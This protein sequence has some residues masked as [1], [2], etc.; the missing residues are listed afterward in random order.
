MWAKKNV[1]QSRDVRFYFDSLHPSHV[2]TTLPSVAGNGVVKVING[3]MQSPASKIIDDDIDASAEIQQSKIQNLTGDLAGLYPRS[4]PSGY[5][6]GI[7]DLVY[8]TGD[9]VIDGLKTFSQGISIDGNSSTSTL[10]VSGLRVGINNENP[11]A[12]LDVSGSAL[13]S[14]RPFVNGTGIVLSGEIDTTNFYTN[15]NPSGFITGVFQPNPDYV[16]IPDLLAKANSTQGG[17]FDRLSSTLYSDS[18]FPDDSTYGLVYGDTYGGEAS[19]WNLI[20]RNDDS[21]YNILGTAIVTGGEYPWSV[22]YSNGVVVTKEA[23]ARLISELSGSASEGSS[24]YAARADHI[25]I[26]PTASEIGAYPTS[27]PS[28]FITSGMAAS[29]YVSSN[30]GNI[31]GATALTNLIQI[32]QS[33]YNA[34]TPSASTVYIIVG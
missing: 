22:S 14:E 21:V 30:I 29:T 8:A 32:T 5:I 7:S 15:N 6:S 28:G 4:N 10:F 1:S 25:H 20:Y 31:S 2:H 16:S 23:A 13:F 11:Q 12:S 9:Q 19:K 3:V 26:F 34:I 24:I 18:G 33:G 27:N 17:P